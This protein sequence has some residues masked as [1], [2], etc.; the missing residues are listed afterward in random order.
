V[1]PSSAD[2]C[3]RDSRRLLQ[4]SDRRGEIRGWLTIIA[5]LLGIP[6]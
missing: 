1:R 4:E 2:H 5:E 3:G 6:G